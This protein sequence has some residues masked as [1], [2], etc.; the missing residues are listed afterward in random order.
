[1]QV[2]VFCSCQLTQQ[3]QDD[4]TKAASGKEPKA[5]RLGQLYAVQATTECFRVNGAIVGQWTRAAV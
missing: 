3:H 5:A 1:M 4:A 2:E